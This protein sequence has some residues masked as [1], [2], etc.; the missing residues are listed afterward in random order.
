M[1]GECLARSASLKK[2]Q[3]ERN[4]GTQAA[5]LLAAALY[6]VFATQ[7]PA[8]AELRSAIYQLWRDDPQERDRTMRLL[9]VEEIRL[10]QFGRA[11]VHVAGRALREIGRNAVGGQWRQAIRAVRG[12]GEWLVWL[13]ASVGPY[14]LSRHASTLRLP[15]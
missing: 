5:E 13:S 11:F 4:A 7:S 14:P 10:A 9:A 3:Q 8:N 15:T 6:Q 1:D 2:Y 12:L